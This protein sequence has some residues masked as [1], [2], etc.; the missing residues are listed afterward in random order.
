M[1]WCVDMHKLSNKVFVFFFFFLPLV[2]LRRELFRSRC[3]EGDGCRG[4]VEG[5][6]A[7]RDGS[8][9][10]CK[11]CGGGVGGLLG[12][13]WGWGKGKVSGDIR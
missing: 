8:F 10:F 5:F 11:G 3:G 1:P 7:E 2:V 6:C 9:F 12:G 13:G 4:D